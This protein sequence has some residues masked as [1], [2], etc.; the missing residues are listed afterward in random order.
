MP[1][2][3]GQSGNPRG[4]KPGSQNRTTAIVKDG[5]LAAYAGIGGDKSFQDWAK[6]NPTEFYT[7]ILTKLVPASLEDGD[8]NPLTIPQ[9][10][11]FVITKAPHADC[12]D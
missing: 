10:I 9:A 4:R 8:G 7:R 12:R 11:A 5:I 2:K 6:A 3:K 1:F